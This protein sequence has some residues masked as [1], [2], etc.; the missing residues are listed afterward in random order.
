MND[1]C[2]ECGFVKYDYVLPDENWQSI[3]SNMANAF[4]YETLRLHRKLR[5]FLKLHKE[6]FHCYSMQVASLITYFQQLVD[7]MHQFLDQSEVYRESHK[8]N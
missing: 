3:I 6:E 5:F 1:V 4:I 8:N 7:E 2:D